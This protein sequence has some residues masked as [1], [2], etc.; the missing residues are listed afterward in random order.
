MLVCHSS[1]SKLFSRDTASNDICQGH[2]QPFMNIANIRESP[3]FN[4]HPPSSIAYQ[5]NVLLA[6][7]R[8]DSKYSPI[9]DISGQ[10][11]TVEKDATA[12]QTRCAGVTGCSFFSFW[13]KDGGCHLSSRAAVLRQASGVTSGPSSC[14]TTGNLKQI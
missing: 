4:L 3:S 9:D 1:A 13:A 14:S 6:C 7:V 11:R 10:R 2:A 8:Q 5:I 12:C